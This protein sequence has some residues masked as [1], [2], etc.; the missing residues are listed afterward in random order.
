MGEIGEPLEDAEQLLIPGPPPHLHVA[1]TAL[2]T[3][4]PEPRQLVATLWSRRH[5]EATE[6]AHQMK[7]LALA[8]L[9]RIPPAAPSTPS[10]TP[11]AKPAG[12]PP[13]R[14]NFVAARSQ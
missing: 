12:R 2:R 9:P 1:G 13:V 5:G 7:R 6:R 14:P 4:W 8:G 11:T 3:E 10:T